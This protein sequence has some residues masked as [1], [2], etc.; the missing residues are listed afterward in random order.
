M[1]QAAKIEGEGRTHTADDVYAGTVTATR[2][3]RTAAAP[4]QNADAQ[5]RIR[6]Q[7]LLLRSRSRNGD[8]GEQRQRRNNN[9]AHTHCTVIRARCAPHSRRLLRAS[10]AATP[11][12]LATCSRSGIASQRDSLARRL[13]V[14]GRRPVLV[15]AVRV[16]VW[17]ARRLPGRRAASAPSTVTCGLMHAQ[18]RHAVREMVDCTIDMLSLSIAVGNA[19]FYFLPHNED[20]AS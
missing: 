14:R 6:I 9:H 18:W 8:H 5:L 13:H 19:P 10:F 2:T 3:A 20:T 4:H 12:L 7:V 1:L 15:V 16:G 11:P 17:C